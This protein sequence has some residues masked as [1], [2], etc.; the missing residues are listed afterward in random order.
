MKLRAA[1]VKGIPSIRCSMGNFMV[2]DLVE[3]DGLN[4]RVVEGVRKKW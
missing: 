2:T 3:A 1:T 4:V